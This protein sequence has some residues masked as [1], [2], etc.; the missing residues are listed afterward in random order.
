MTVGLHT[1][2][3]RVNDAATVKVLTANGATDVE[4]GAGIPGWG[5]P[6]AYHDLPEKPG[7]VYVTEVTHHWDGE[8]Y[9]LGGGGTYVESFGGNLD[10]PLPCMIGSDLESA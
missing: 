7:Q 6:H 2:H 5:M 9:T 4:P 8:T 3:V 10:Y 1:V